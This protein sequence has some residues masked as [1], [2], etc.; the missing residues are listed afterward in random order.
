MGL[1]AQTF[2]LIESRK[3][4]IMNKKKYTHTIHGAQGMAHAAILT[5]SILHE[6]MLCETICGKCIRI[7]GKYS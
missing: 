2:L 7:A 3:G 1:R 6:N 4:T 5:S